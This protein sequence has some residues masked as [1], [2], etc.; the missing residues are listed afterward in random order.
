MAHVFKTVIGEYDATLNVL[1]LAE[2]LEG[3]SD[4]ERVVLMV[5]IASQSEPPP[6]MHL[7][8]SL[9]GEAGEELAR[10]VEEMFPIERD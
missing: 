2:P 7:A 1:R 5:H 4:H 8:G 3:V 9:S 10:L 6:W